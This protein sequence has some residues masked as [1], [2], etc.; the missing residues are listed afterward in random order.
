[1]I[2]F[3][4]VT[5]SLALFIFRSDIEGG[6]WF[7]TGAWACSGAATCSTLFERGKN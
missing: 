3:A 6:L 2:I 5:W 7:S 4:L 1:M